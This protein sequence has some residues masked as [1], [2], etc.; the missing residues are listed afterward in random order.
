[1]ITYM[2]RMYFILIAYLL[3]GYYDSY[4]QPY[5]LKHLGVEDGLSNNYVTNITQD[6]QGYIWIAT[7]SGLSRFDGRNFTTYKDNDSGIISNALNALL[8][9]E[10]ENAL[11][12]GLKDGLSKLDCSTYQFTNNIA[13]SIASNIVALAHSADN[14]GIWITNHYGGT[15][16][17]NKQTKQFSPFSHKNIKDLYDSSWCSFDNG[18]GSLYIGHAQGG[19]SI[20][21]LKS[22]TCKNYR[23]DPHNPK[24]LPGNSVY[25]IYIDHS[26]NIWIGTNQGLALFNSQ[27]EEFLTFKHEFGNPHSLIADHIYC[28]KEMNDGTLWIGADIGGISILDLHSITFMNPKSVKFTNISASNDESGLSSSNI[29]SLLQDSFGNIWI[30]NYSS[31][32]NFIS[33]TKPVFH[34][35]PYTTEKGKTLKN[36]PVWGIST[37]KEGQVWVGSENEVAIFKDYQLT[38]TLNITPFLSRPYG[39]VFSLRSDQKQTFLLGIYDDGLLKLNTKTNRIERIPL[40]MDNIDIITFFE[41]SDGTMLIGA[42]YGVYI[43]EN[44]TARVAEEI[45]NQLYARSVYGILR[46]RQGKLWIGTYGGGISIFD[47]DNK[48]TMR[49]NTDNSFCSN[50]INQLYL[51]SLGEV[52]VATRNG[53]AH[54]KNTMQPE[55]FEAYNSMHGLDDNFV[56]A[57]QEDKAGNIW[58]SSNDGISR[59]NSK[60]QLFENYNHH[61][62]IPAGNFIE[63]SACSTEDGILYFGSLNGVC[64]FDPKELITEHQ[65]APVQIT[66]C[67]GFNRQIESHNAGV[68]IPTTN[69]NIDLPYNQNSFRISFTVPDYSQSQLVEYAYMIEGLENVK[70]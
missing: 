29:R 46:D 53:I 33:H 11:W 48:L 23:N 35:L 21:D 27:T 57:I 69:G 18:H 64:Y 54:I 31:G 14:K 3:L 6:K 12:I 24:S 65:V 51:N 2:Q 4:A 10:E 7:E 20:I 47:K 25:C 61:D 59:W 52:W 36:K 38:K 28:I 17:Y 70:S 50:A 13:D 42:E 39:Q 63:G 15:I 66:E 30:G 1:M 19:L 26:G 56:R 40:G 68:L 16:Y 45:T 58:I 44:G 34:T 67:K 60:K 5:L 49:L 9:D 22:K 32:I 41:D 43:Y 37:D 8:Y 55:H 62:G